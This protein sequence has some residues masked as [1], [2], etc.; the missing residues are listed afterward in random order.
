M[1]RKDMF[2]RLLNKSF[3]REGVFLSLVCVFSMLCEPS[4]EASPITFVGKNPAIFSDANPNGLSALMNSVDK[5][6]TRRTTPT[7]NSSELIIRGLESQITNKIYNDIFNT[8]NPSG[9]FQLP[10]GGQISFVRPGD[11]NIVITIV[12]SANVTSV[13]TVPDI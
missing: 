1:F 13:I 11:G 2:N 6:A 10:S 4:A 5:P 9:I 3:I 7:P 8:A 12:N